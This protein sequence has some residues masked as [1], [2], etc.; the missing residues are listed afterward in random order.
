MKKYQ[1]I[2][3]WVR[4]ITNMQMSIPSVYAWKK[5]KRQRDKNLNQEARRRAGG[6]QIIAL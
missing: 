3:T 2:P 1:R 6:Q 5:R 4:A